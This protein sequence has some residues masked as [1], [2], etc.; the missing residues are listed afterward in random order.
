MLHNDPIARLTP[1]VVAWRHHIH[2]NPELGFQEIETARFVAEKLRSFGLEVQERIGGT[3]VV[4]TLRAGSGKRAIGLRAELDALP[5]IERT[6]LPYASKTEGVMHACG[7]DGH[8]AML[9]GAAKLLSEAPD[10]DGTV[11]FIFQPAEENEGGSMKM[12]EAGLFERFPVEAVYAVHN[13]PGVPFGTIAARA[14]AQMAA[15]DNFELRFSGLGAHVAMP[16]LGDDPILAAGA[17][18]QSVQRI[19][20][21]AVDPQT[22]IVVSL[23]QVHGGNVG[24]IVPK[25][26]WL[27]GTCRFFDPALSDLCERL[28]G[29]IADGVAASHGVTAAL[30]Y[31]RGYPPV[32]NAAEAAALAA[33]AAAAAVGP[34]NVMAEFKPSLGCEDFA[35]MIRAA[36]GCYAWIGAGEVG[37]GEGL[38]GDRYVFND[39]IV[40]H[41]LRYWQSLVAGALPKVA[42]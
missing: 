36:G 7:H 31:K 37:P 17:F 38:H 39:A 26:V 1:E 41:V 13:W 4:G 9:L 27:Q 30:D 14:G 22:P 28:I 5:V 10:F 20:S 15:V 23:T 19:V 29:E 33:R 35:F 18:I 11:H 42:P 40:P 24:N 34:E 12:I 21:R 6:G 2:A 8:S 25:E 16:H 32:I 3:G